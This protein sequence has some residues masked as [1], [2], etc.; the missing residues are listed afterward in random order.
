MVWVKDDKLPL[1][2]VCRVAAIE[3][4]NHG[5][6]GRMLFKDVTLEVTKGDRIAIIGPNGAGA[7]A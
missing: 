4:L 3:R 6:G 7:L 1:L 5:Y 2:S